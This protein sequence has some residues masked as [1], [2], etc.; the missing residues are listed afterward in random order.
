MEKKKQVVTLKSYLKKSFVFLLSLSIVALL[1]IVGL[2]ITLVFVKEKTAL[3]IISGCAALVLGT[4][5]IFVI[6]LSRK[7]YQILYCQALEVS[8]RNF[9]AL[10]NFDKD[11]EYCPRNDFEEFKQLNSTFKDLSKNLDGRTIISK[12]F[13]YNGVGLVY[14]DED[15]VV[16]SEKSLIDNV[17][18]LILASESY[19]NALI[20]ISYKLGKDA[21]ANKDK[22]NIIK[23]LKKGLN[24]EH[25]L[26]AS[27]ES[28]PGFYVYVPAFDSISQLKEELEAVIKN[29]SLVR[30]LFV[31]KQVL[32]AHINAVI[33][34][35]S[36]I[37]SMV[38]DL[39]IATRQKKTFNIYLPE[40]GVETNKK[41]LMSSMNINNTS[42]L[43]EQISA[44]DADPKQYD[45][46]MQKIENS[47]A[48]ISNYY[49]FSCSGYIAFD[50][51]RDGY[52]S[53]FVHSDTDSFVFRQ[54][55]RMNRNFIQVINNIQ[56]ADHSY[57]FSSR[58]HVN[59]DFARFIDK[60]RF[61]SGMFYVLTKNDACVGVIYFLNKSSDMAFDAYMKENLIVSCHCIGNILKEMENRLQVSVAMQQF[62]GMF[63]ISDLSI[64]SFDKQTYEISLMSDLFKHT[65]PKIKVGDICYKAIYGLDAPCKNCPLKTGKHKISEEGKR[66]YEIYQILPNKNDQYAHMIRKENESGIPSVRYDNETLLLTHFSFNDMLSRFLSLNQSGNV[67]F[68]SIR[69][70]KDI[71][72]KAGNAGYI[73]LMRRLNL[74]VSD[75]YKGQHDIYMYDN[76][77]LAIILPDSQEDDIVSVAE[78]ICEE[79]SNMSLD[80][81]NVKLN[82]VYIAKSF[83]NN[84]E[85]V[86]TMDKEF[87]KAIK[88]AADLPIDEILFVDSGY[89][90]STS[91]EGYLYEMAVDAFT[92]NTFI[93]N[94]QP[95]VDNKD[96]L[97][98]GAELVLRI[99][100]NERNHKVDIGK[101][102]RIVEARGQTSTISQA[103][104]NYIDDILTKYGYTF[105]LTSG[106]NRLAFNADINFFLDDP[107]FLKRIAIIN[108]KHNLSKGFI[109]LQVFESDVK[110]HAEEYATIAKEVSASGAT[111]ICDRYSGIISAKEVA[112][113]GFKEIK[114][115]RDLVVAIA[116]KNVNAKIVAI[117]A[118]AVANGLKTIFVGVENRLISEAIHYEEYDCFVQGNYFFIPMSEEA[119][120]ES[121]RQ[122]N[123]KDSDVNN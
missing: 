118:D 68:L 97:I 65:H 84:L 55:A 98:R 52:F 18:K 10:A 35:Y 101:A 110:D 34:P 102:I 76:N 16:V 79:T 82:L 14:L 47:I 22:E 44:I 38:S 58:K 91:E 15:E 39:A 75:K 46:N 87:D 109:G 107:E 90:R 73:E 64:Y 104:L 108:G 59:N 95:V 12:A 77:T 69:N 96:R 2:I 57:Y 48:S 111:L 37:D 83:D 36:D 115:T 27:K 50:E 31:G 11:F 17:N 105:F 123:M 49:G 72:E 85:N 3:Y 74:F 112:A 20:D 19:R 7:F 23:S 62:K 93:V 24:Y 121:I 53:R 13:T 66:T 103:I 80:E 86:K 45:K 6:I 88:Q 56:D 114:I 122:R 28:T 42:R 29:I 33:Y 43:I 70:V 30:R 61:R 1:A 92:K 116:E 113:A 4:A 40:R 67:L 60:Y 21:I 71:I 120:F 26:I 5:L 32:I 8:R 100:D 117:W 89:K 99:E 94:F 41:M 106:L 9:E 78:S 63:R 81:S 25:L 54:N 119:L 51:T